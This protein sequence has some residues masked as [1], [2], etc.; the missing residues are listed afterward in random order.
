[1]N[2]FL[3]DY[4]FG[5]LRNWSIFT[6]ISAGLLFA[7]ALVLLLVSL[8]RRR[9]AWWQNAAFLLGLAMGAWSLLVAYDAYQQW[10][11]MVQQTPPHAYAVTSIAFADAYRAGIARCQIQCAVNLIAIILILLV[12]CWSAWSSR[13]PRTVSQSA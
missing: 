9:Y 13:R 3:G 6:S 10:S 12:A 2:L 5:D 4:I 7:G 11:A 8:V 1:M